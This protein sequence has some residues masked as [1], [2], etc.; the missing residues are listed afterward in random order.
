MSMK[1]QKPLLLQYIRRVWPSI[2]AKL[3]PVVSDTGLTRV[4]VVVPAFPSMGGILTVLDGIAQISEDSWNIEYLAQFLE[5][6][7]ERYTVHRFGSRRMTPLYFP[8]A[9][10]YVM[11]GLL[12]FLSLMRRGAGFRLLLPQ[13]G[14]F[15]SALAGIAGKLTGVR[16]ICI[17]H[18]DISLFTPRN[19]QIY[20]EERTAAIATKNWPWL[21]RFAAK[22]LLSLYWPSRYIAARIGAQFVDHYLIPGVAG[23]SIAEGCRVIGIPPHR[24]TR[25]GSMIDI[26]RHGALNA[27]NRASLRESKGLPANSIVVTIACRLS[28]EKGLD[29][30]LESINSALRLLPSQQ[31]ERVQ[32]VI[33]GDGPLRV[34]LE[35]DVRQ[36]HLEAV[37]RFWGELR[38]DEVRELL[39]MSDIFLYTS[40]RGACMAM[41]ILE[42]MASACAV[43][44]TTEPLANALLLAEGRGIVVPPSDVEQT[45]NALLR[46]L[47]NVPLCHQM[48]ALAREYM[49]DHHSP[50]QFKQLLLA[51]SGCSSQD[52]AAVP[53]IRQLE[54]GAVALHTRG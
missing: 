7:H 41:A 6:G 12:K 15:S 50:A 18:G 44:A 17:D 3:F 22:S 21:V 23:D 34:K 33:A 40:T 30:A 53:L 42:A 19:S 37:C 11:S 29:I 28:A 26:T 9:W 13:D 1:V 25:F 4:C 2:Q 49:C 47:Q 38:P 14:I 10:L 8:F 32:V 48:G 54:K 39:S 36:R 16:V 35:Q 51:V 31:R 27:Q 5:A 43:I 46:L 24:V 45:R 20:R 52:D